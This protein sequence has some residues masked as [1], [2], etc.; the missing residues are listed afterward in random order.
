[1]EKHP[2]PKAKGPIVKQPPGIGHS[3]ETREAAFG[4]TDRLPMRPGEEEGAE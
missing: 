4:I 2:K 1:M 3:Y